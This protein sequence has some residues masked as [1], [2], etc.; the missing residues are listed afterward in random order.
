M[1]W[2]VAVGEVGALAAAGRRRVARRVPGVRAPPAA[3][4]RGAVAAS[5][6]AP[7]PRTRPFG[8]DAWDEARAGARRMERERP[9]AARPE[10]GPGRLGPDSPRP[11]DLDPRLMPGHVAVI[12]DGNGRW[13]RGRG[14]GVGEGHE[15]GAESLRTLVKCCN[16]WGVDTATVYAFSM[17]NWERPDFEVNFLLGLME[18]LLG[19]ESAELHAQ[20]VC[21]Q[22]VGDL[23]RLPSQ[24]RAEMD[25]VCDLTRGNPGLRL[26][27]AVS[28]GGRQD[29]VQACARIAT[30]VELGTLRASDVDE[31]LVSDFLLLSKTDGREGEEH[32]KSR[33]RREP[34]LLIR[35]SGEL[36]LS[37]F[38]LWEM[39]YTELHF[40]DVMW[41]D[42]GAQELYEALLSYQR[43]QRRYGARPPGA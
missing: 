6:G 8:G 22:F 23:G 7:P 21:V 12:M 29:I 32:V 27:L 26:N 33:Q 35:T 2:L 40:T 34:D 4:R 43:R 41:P 17:E 42:F 1:G 25:R 13:A 11:A 37:N 3:G 39:A 19:A 10:D 31:A 15:Q 30:E 20:R 9:N 18:R 36:R 14:R 38:L 28:Y 24:L 5:L 16:N